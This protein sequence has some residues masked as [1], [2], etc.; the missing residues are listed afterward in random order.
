MGGKKVGRPVTPDWLQQSASSRPVPPGPLC[1]WSVCYAVNSPSVIDPNITPSDPDLPRVNQSHQS[2]QTHQTNQT[3][4]LLLP[5]TSSS[6]SRVAIL[7]VSRA[8]ASITTR[9]RGG[10]C[11]REGYSKKA[12]RRSVW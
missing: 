10:R 1:E 9:V 8:I 5:Q 4:S 6:A 3:Q 12:G 2:H 7:A 11:C